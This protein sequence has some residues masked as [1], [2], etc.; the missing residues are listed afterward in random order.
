MKVFLLICTTIILSIA[1]GQICQARLNQLI[2]GQC[3]SVDNCQG[4]ILATTSCGQQRCC[5]NGTS[6]NTVQICLDADYFDTLYN[7][8]RAR[9]LRG[10]L[11]YGIS[12][13]GICQNCQA[14]AAFLAIAATMTNNF[15]TDEAIGNDTEFTTDD[16]KYGNTQAGDGSRFRR[17]GFFGLRG[18]T[19]YQRLQLLAPQY[20]NLSNPEAAAIV[21]NAIE[22]AAIL[23]N[24][25]SLS[26]GKEEFDFDSD[27]CCTG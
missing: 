26:N 17:R 21:E 10:I 1:D 24:N 23:W 20:G 7:T 19:M 25:P 15:Q 22:I 6:L 12:V 9:F 13:S 5:L 3:F 2:N 14:K 4:T 16:N 8:S 18:R 27:R 11:N